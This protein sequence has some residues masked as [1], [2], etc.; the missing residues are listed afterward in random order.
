MK[1]TPPK[2]SRIKISRFFK[3]FFAPMFF[4][5][6]ELNGMYG[7]IVFSRVLLIKRLKLIIP[8]VES[9]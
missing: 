3:I 1:N 7:K 9:P 2:F 5:H 6:H 8:M 4:K